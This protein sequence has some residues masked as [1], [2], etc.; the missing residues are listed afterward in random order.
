M[1]SAPPPVS[2][3]SLSGACWLTFRR[4]NVYVQK[5]S[6][7]DRPYHLSWA[8]GR[9]VGPASCGWQQ[10]YSL[11]SKDGHGNLTRCKCRIYGSS[12][13][14]EAILMIPLYLWHK[15][16]EYQPPFPRE[17][18]SGHRVH[19]G[20]SKDLGFNPL[21]WRKP[22]PFYPPEGIRAIS[23][24]SSCYE[25]GKQNIRDVDSGSKST[26]LPLVL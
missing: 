6:S 10:S 18:A 20:I 24:S 25:G 19:L 2:V 12:S 11:A 5:Q 4:R 14:H 22:F 17:D 7:P 8:L 9:G 3:F 15:Q 13:H 21:N 16:Q 1:L 26:L 23:N